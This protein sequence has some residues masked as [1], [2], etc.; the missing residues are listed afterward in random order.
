VKAVDQENGIL[1]QEIDN[2]KI[3]LDVRRTLAGN[4]ARAILQ[5]HNVRAAA[6]RGIFE[7][8]PVRDRLREIQK[9]RNAP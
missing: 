8:D 2:L 5:R 4:S 7:G 9:P 3:E 6:S 1:K